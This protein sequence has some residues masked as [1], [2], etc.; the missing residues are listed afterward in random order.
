VCLTAR[1]T[2]R[3]TPLVQGEGGRIVPIT[4][5]LE[6]DAIRPSAK[7]EVNHPGRRSGGGKN[8]QRGVKKRSID[9]GIGDPSR[10]KNPSISGEDGVKR[11][12]PGKQRGA[13]KS[14][15][16]CGPGGT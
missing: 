15:P 8:F 5:T 2:A 4:S 13:R 10:E 9:R 3:A 14:G 7:K 1:L 12:P 11:S 6:E 16:V